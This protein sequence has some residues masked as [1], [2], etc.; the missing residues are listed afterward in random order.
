M[1]LYTAW[2][3]ELEIR[4]GLMHWLKSIL[5]LHPRTLEIP[6]IYPRSPHAISKFYQLV[7]LEPALFGLSSYYNQLCMFLNFCD[8]SE[9]RR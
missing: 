2:H 1:G 9:I 4:M 8:Y 3:T 5:W 7:I 6:S